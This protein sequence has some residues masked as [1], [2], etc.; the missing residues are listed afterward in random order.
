MKTK[1]SK[2]NPQSVIE[3]LFKKIQKGSGK[4]PITVEIAN[5]SFTATFKDKE[6]KK[7][8]ERM[9]PNTSELNRIAFNNKVIAI[10]FEK[11][12]IDFDL[13]NFNLS[14]KKKELKKDQIVTLIDF[15]KKIIQDICKE[16]NYLS[17]V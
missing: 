13:V 2:P 4:L 12:N 6:F 16:K 15:I 3:K 8:S 7:V 11:N 10:K 5:D 14:Y 17:P 1:N 9:F